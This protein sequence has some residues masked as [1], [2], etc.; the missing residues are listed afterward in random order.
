M[1]IV[2]ETIDGKQF[3]VEAEALA[4][5]ALVLEKKA[6]R[7]KLMAILKITEPRDYTF[8]QILNAL[9]DAR[10]KITLNP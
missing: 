3:N 5:E 10:D 9:F 4:W 6:F 1:K 7:T 2:Y 8:V